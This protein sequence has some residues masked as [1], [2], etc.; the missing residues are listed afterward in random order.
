MYTFQ[1]STKILLD[2]FSAS[3]TL[4][5]PHIWQYPLPGAG[6]QVVIIRVTDL[7]DWGIDQGQPIAIRSR[8]IFGHYLFLSVALTFQMIHSL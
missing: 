8:N 1:D 6:H 3:C 4:L 7:T 5:E 2:G